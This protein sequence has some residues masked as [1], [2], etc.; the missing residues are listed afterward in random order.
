MAACT[1]A[2]RSRRSASEV[3]PSAIRAA[4]VF[5][6]EKEK[7]QSLRPSSMRG[8][9][10]RLASPPSASFSSAGTTDVALFHEGKI[11]HVA[12]LGY[13]GHNVT[14]DIV[15]GLGVTQADAEESY[16]FALPGFIPDGRIDVPGLV[17]YV[18]DEKADGTLPA[19]FQVER[20]LDTTL[21]EEALR[22]LEAGR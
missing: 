1:A 5:R 11:R 9:S 14:S 15:H 6:P 3:R 22:A 17:R 10:K 16:D 7:S 2:A 12:T 8:S 21:A 4:A 13:G 19:E 20:I 18:A